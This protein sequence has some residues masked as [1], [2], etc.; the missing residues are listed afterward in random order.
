MNIFVSRNPHQAINGRQIL[1]LLRGQPP[2]LIFNRLEWVL[3]IIDG[4][5]LIFNL[6]FLVL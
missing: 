4:D 6:T 3:G 1:A 2:P 5:V